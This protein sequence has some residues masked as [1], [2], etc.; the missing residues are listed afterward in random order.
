MER[1]STTQALPDEERELVALQVVEPPVSLRHRLVTGSVLVVAGLL[2]VFALGLGARAG[3]AHFTLSSIGATRPLRLSPP[4]AGTA[5]ALGAVVIALGLWQIGHGFRQ[6]VF[7]YVVAATLVAVV[8]AFLLW[9]AS[10]DTLPLLGLTQNTIFLATPLVLGALSG[11]M[12][13]R[14]GV[15]NLSIEGQFLVGAFAAALAATVAHNLYVGVI[16]AVIAGGLLG[17][18]LAVFAIRYVVNQ[19]VLGVVLNVFALGLTGF[20]YDAVMQRNQDAFNNPGIFSNVKI[21]LLG[22][23]PVLG[24]LLFDTTVLVYATYVLIIAV[25]VFLFRTRWGLRTRAVGEHPQAADTVGIQVNRLR[26]WNT[27]MGGMIA[28][29]GGAYLTIGTVG[30]FSKNISSG[31]GFIA[32]AALIFGRWSPRGAL[33]AGLL[34]GFADALQQ[35]L[36]S[37]GTP[38]AIPSSFMAMLPYLATLFAVAG[39]VGRVR[40][41]G[42][43]G[44]PYVKG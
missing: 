29:L 10:G 31:K 16:A 6:R 2:T 37:L 40:A 12:C 5:I 36:S 8:V 28:G 22:D 19:V 35:M 38:V 15:I 30:A 34:F 39:L 24:P 42:A 3:K 4:A 26:F 11:V 44:E 32:L 18:L 27:V 17:A 23:I 21:P 33:G 7:R 20:I 41:P 13:E 43:D 9:A 14:S 1:M 25:D